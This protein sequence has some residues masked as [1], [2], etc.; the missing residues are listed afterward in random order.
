MSN[1]L[2]NYMK[3]RFDSDKVVSKKKQIKTGPVVTISREYG[4]PAKRLAGMLSSALNKIELDNYTKHR[5][6]WIGKEILDES[7]KE[8]KL[9]PSMIREV[10]NKEDSGVVDDIVMSLSY[11]YYPGDHKI[12]KTIGE[13]IRSFAEQGHVII[14]GRG[15][16][17]ITRDI[18]DSLHLKI[19]APLEWRIN[20]VSKNQMISLTEAKKKIQTIDM[21]RK[22][23]SEY[24][25]GG[26]VD[27]SAFDV[28]FNYMTL[29]DE[30]IIAT[31]IRL[32]ESKD[33]I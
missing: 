22:M 18:S 12:K 21:Q 20:Y 28:I 33:L 10:A 15:G 29:D 26:K 5:W 9:K 23:I 27:N 3:Q 13:V 7:A 24:F 11:K 2:L 17:S 14:V 25:E 30:D 1:V 31:I 16:V 6:Q 19:Q 4:C 32:M 8:L